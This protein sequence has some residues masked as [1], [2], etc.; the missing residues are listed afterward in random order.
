MGTMYRT[1]GFTIVE[2]LI[3]VVVI[4]I[5]AAI[6]IVSYNGISQRAYNSQ[7]LSGVQQYYKAIESY[8]ALNGR[9][10]PTTEEQAGNVAVTLTCLGTGYT[11]SACGTVTGRAITEDALFNSSMQSVIGGTPPAIGKNAIQVGGESFSGAVYGGDETWCSKSSTCYGRTIQ[12]GLKGANQDCKVSNSFAY[13]SSDN[14][15]ACEIV[16][17]EMVRP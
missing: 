14:T 17:E 12:W 1:N 5:L 16:L 2:L 6:T 4:A 10:P 7:I 3:V 11:G 15:T 13:N 8:K 9:Y